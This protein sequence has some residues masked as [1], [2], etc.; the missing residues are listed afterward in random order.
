MQHTSSSAS[1]ARINLVPTPC[2]GTEATGDHS[3]ACNF[4]HYLPDLLNAL[5]V[6][7]GRFSVSG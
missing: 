7:A 1:L 5:M 4:K 6:P 3:H 2:A